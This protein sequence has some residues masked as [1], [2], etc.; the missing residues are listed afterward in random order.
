MRREVYLGLTSILLYA[1]A[2]LGFAKLARGQDLA[3]LEDWTE[4]V[5]W[6]AAVAVSFQNH[7]CSGVPIEPTVVLT[8]A[9]CV[10]GQKP[11]QIRVSVFPG[12]EILV[13]G[14]VKDPGGRDIARL[15]L[16]EPAPFVVP[17]AKAMPGPVEVVY[18]VGFGCDNQTEI[19][20][21]TYAGPTKT[22]HMVMTG[23]CEG[24]SGGPVF[25]TSGELLGIMKSRVPG[26]PRMFFTGVL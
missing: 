10:K 3:P 20:L 9:H 24:D 6:R 5:P 1:T 21:G 26:K 7:M 11:S 17:I 22:S 16:N 19:H 18:A 8:A 13:S 12:R 4:R 23:V 14:V 25:N 15:L 2:L